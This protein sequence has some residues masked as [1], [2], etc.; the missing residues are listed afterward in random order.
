MS[1]T[2][3]AHIC[4]VLAPDLVKFNELNYPNNLN[5]LRNLT[6]VGILGHSTVDV[7]ID[8]AKHRESGGGAYRRMGPG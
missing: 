3:V 1:G 8:V 2:K 4:Q 6:I 5:E 7:N